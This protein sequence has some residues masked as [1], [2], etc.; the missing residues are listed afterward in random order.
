MGTYTTSQLNP[1]PA[2]GTWATVVATI[3]TDGGTLSVQL[4]G[5]STP[6]AVAASSWSI[7]GPLW[8]LGFSQPWDSTCEISYVSVGVP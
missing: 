1:L 7:A 2:E 3:R 6:T 4:D 8:K 5:Q